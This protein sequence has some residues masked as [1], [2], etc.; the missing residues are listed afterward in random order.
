MFQRVRVRS[1]SIILMRQ[2]LPYETS[3]RF[4]LK[5][6]P[7]SPC[8]ACQSLG[9]SIPNIGMILDGNRNFR[10]H[11]K[12]N[13][14][15]LSKLHCMLNARNELF[16][17]CKAWFSLPAYAQSWSTLVRTLPTLVHLPTIGCTVTVYKS[18]VFVF[19][20]WWRWSPVHFFHVFLI[21]PHHILTIHYV[22]TAINYFLKSAPSITGFVY[23]L[24]K[25]IAI[26]RPFSSRIAYAVIKE[27][28]RVKPGTNYRTRLRSM[29]CIQRERYLSA[30]RTLKVTSTF[31]VW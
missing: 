5:K 1:H 21:Y 19:D 13:L 2:I 16:I 15:D 29:L 12:T 7:W 20:Y 4:P 26:D 30:V 11:I 18:T 27:R 9:K 14:F 3:S 10:D 22:K 6:T 8:L 23:F 28:G 31:Y 25:V 24:N 17:K